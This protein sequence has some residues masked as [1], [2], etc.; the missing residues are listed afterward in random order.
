MIGGVFALFFTGMYL[1]VPA[2][3]GFIALL[4]IAVEN[5]VVMLSFFNQL[6]ERG[7]SL[8]AAVIEGSE[9]RLRPILMTSLLTILGLV[10]L[11]ISTGPGSEIQKPLA[12]VVVGGVFTSTALTLVL[13]PIFYAWIERW[14]ASRAASG[15]PGILRRSSSPAPAT[16]TAGE[17]EVT[18]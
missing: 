14:A 9:K 3:L 15:R 5:G 8:E 6:R 16:Q 10:P 17:T 4:G 7:M 1:S 11:L 18:S 2:S 12:V 13:L